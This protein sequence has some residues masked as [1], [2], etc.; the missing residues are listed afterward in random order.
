VEKKDGNWI[1]NPKID[2]FVS[3]DVWI[4]FWGFTL[5]YFN[6]AMEHGHL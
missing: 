2:R 6:I 4:A 3:W 1:W 5:W